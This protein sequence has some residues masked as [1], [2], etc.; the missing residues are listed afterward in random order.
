MN[1]PNPH[2]AADENPEWTDEMFQEAKTK[3]GRPQSPNP[4]QI[5]SFRLSQDLIQGIISSGSGYNTRVEQVLREALNE[6]KI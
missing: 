1:K 6:G 2:K 4:K 3:R 5:K